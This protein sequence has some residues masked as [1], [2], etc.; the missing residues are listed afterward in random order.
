MFETNQ[1]SKIKGEFTFHLLPQQYSGMGS[2]KKKYLR[3]QKKNNINK[4]IKKRTC[5]H[6]KTQAL[7]GEQYFVFLF[8]KKQIENQP[9]TSTS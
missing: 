3:Y 5:S 9:N 8:T 4:K 7:N 6:S 2:G 1:R